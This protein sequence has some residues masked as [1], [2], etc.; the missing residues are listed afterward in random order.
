VVVVSGGQMPR[1]IS[2]EVVAVVAVVATY[3]IVV[4]VMV[5]EKGIM[6]CIQIILDPGFSI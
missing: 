3:C 5:M 6:I 2:S 4:V 1:W